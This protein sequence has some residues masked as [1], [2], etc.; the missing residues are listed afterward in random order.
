MTGDEKAF[1]EVGLEIHRSYVRNAPLPDFEKLW[2][3]F[4]SIA[5]RI[6]HARGTHSG[7]DTGHPPIRDN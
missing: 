2:A 7:P 1:V 3:S 5:E 6:E 4:K